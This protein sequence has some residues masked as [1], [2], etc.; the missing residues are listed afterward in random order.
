MR[1]L[2]QS[3]VAMFALGTFMIGCNKSEDAGEEWTG[4]E[5]AVVVHV[6][7]MS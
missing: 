6:P 3:T 1:A 5:P 2:L 7:G 4:S